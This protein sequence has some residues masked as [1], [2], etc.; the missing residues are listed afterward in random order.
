MTIVLDVAHNAPA[1]ERLV[2]LLLK[3]FPGKAFRFVCGFSADKDIPKVIQTLISVTSYDKIHL[4]KANHPRGASLEEIH[5]ALPSTN[6]TLTSI[7]SVSD[8]VEAALTAAREAQE[9]HEEVVVVC[10]SVFLMAETRQVL[11]FREPVDSKELIAVAGSH[12]STPTSRLAQTESQPQAHG[13]GQLHL[14]NI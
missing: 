10:G 12:L 7:S 4:V 8:G 2:Q 3:R 9:D 6:A 1:I 13:H 11:G 5:T 14:S